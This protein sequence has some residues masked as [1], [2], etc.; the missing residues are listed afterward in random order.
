MS[1]DF[2]HGFGGVQQKH[3][4]VQGF[5]RERGGRDPSPGAEKISTTA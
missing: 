5:S 1:A 3:R 4:T 2:P